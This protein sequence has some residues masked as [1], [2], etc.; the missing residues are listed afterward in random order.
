[1]SEF[2]NC[3]SANRGLDSRVGLPCKLENTLRLEAF[4]GSDDEQ[5]GVLNPR[6][7]EYARGCRITVY[8]QKAAT[9]EFLDTPSVLLDHNKRKALRFQGFP[10]NASYPTIAYE[11]RVRPR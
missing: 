2:T 8:G 10:D 7:F 6:A 3:V 4:R 11:H 9:A 1:M 5:T